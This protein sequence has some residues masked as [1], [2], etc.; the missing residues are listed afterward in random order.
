LPKIIN[1]FLLLFCISKV[2]AQEIIWQKTLGGI[3]HDWCSFIK[4]GKEDNYLVAGYTY[5]NNTGDI[6]DT[7]NGASDIWLVSLKKEDASIQWQK[8]LGGNGNDYISQ[9]IETDDGGYLLLG[10]STSDS[11]G[12]KTDIFY[13]G[14]DD[15]WIIKLDTNLNIEWDIT[16]GGSGTDRVA[17]AVVTNQGYLIASESDSPISGSKTAALKGESDIWLLMV[18]F[19]GNE[20]WQ[21]TLG[22]NQ[23]DIPSQ[24]MKT[25][26][27]NFIIAGSSNSPISQDKSEDILSDSGT[28][29]FWIIKINSLGE[30]IWDRVYGGTNGDISDNIIQS[31]DGNFVISG[32][33]YSQINFDKSE[34]PICNSTDIWIL[35][36]TQNGTVIW[37]RTLGG[38]Y[39][40]SATAL[41]ENSSGN[42]VIAGDTYSDPIGYVSEP[43]NGDSDYWLTIISQN[44]E[45]I[46]DKRFG[47]SGLDRNLG[48]IQDSQSNYIQIG[49]SNSGISGDKTESNYSRDWWI[50]KFNL[51]D[52]IN[53]LETPRLTTLSGCLNSDLTLEASSGSRYEWSGPNGFFSTVKNPNLTD[54]NIEKTGPYRV[55]VYSES[56]C[57]KEEI[58]NIQLSENCEENITNINYT[59]PEFF[60]PNNDGYN[61]LW[62]PLSSQSQIIEKVNI[63][64]RFGK[65]LKSLNENESWD[66]TYN[67]RMLPSTDYWFEATFTDNTF[68]TGHFTLKR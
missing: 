51:S 64:N 17:N 15:I 28:L 40:E 46:R 47:G 12:D 18:D 32:T 5:N 56:N 68:K 38:N 66:G 20:I 41:F 62:T 3:N 35:K 7:N 2:Q 58:V 67:G 30:I 11:N 4:E 36:I 60:T 39:E 31:S 6:T 37:D 27:G 19:D 14:L 54:I 22:G 50:L 61:D 21:K 13:G 43:S 34:A 16:Y 45:F 25:N 29:D 49:W 10:N 23:I 63:F 1:I 9:I 59:F 42:I 48:A 44:G 33:S 57:F 52:D 26:D 65:L 53:D 8:T 55:K 24:I